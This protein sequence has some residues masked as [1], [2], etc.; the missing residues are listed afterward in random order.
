MPSIELP[1]PAG[2][3]ALVTGAGRG[4]GKEIA[5]ALARAGVDVGVTARSVAEIEVVAAEIQALGRQAVAVPCDVADATKVTR[6]VTIV[7]E[8][9]GP[10]TILVN[11]AGQGLSHKFLDHP[12]ALWH[13]MIAVNLHSTYYVSKA[14]VPMMVEAGWGRII[15]IAS[16]SSKVGARYLAA[17]TAAKHGVLGLTRALAAEFVK[18][19]ITVNAVC[20]GYVD[21]PMTDAS[22]ANIVARTG[23]SEAEARATLANMSPQQ[24]LIQPEEVAAVVMLLVSEVARG[25][26][27]QAIN[28]DGGAVMF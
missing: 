8:Q 22:V 19:N 13:Q 6:M 1:A 5:L 4:I 14:V 2:R 20:P 25:I 7:G 28:V 16:V 21:T 9:L 17:Y 23:M 26:N 24:R 27:G 12:D 10:V 18:N 11:N 15:N 3:I